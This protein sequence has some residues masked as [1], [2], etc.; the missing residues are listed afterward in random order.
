VR[1]Y[2]GPVGAALLLIALIA[3]YGRPSGQPAGP[4]LRRPGALAAPTTSRQDLDRTIATMQARVTEQPGDATA[5]VQLADA[6]LRQT[7]VTG[8]AGLSMRAEAALNAALTAD[9]SS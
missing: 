9:S 3:W 6:L 8:N 7:R 2:G 5:A 1:K 4:V